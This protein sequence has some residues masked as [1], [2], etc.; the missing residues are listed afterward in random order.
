ME[1]TNT[2]KWAYVFPGQGSQW[3][4]MGY[5][6]Y[7]NYPEAKAIFD[8]SDDVMGFSLSQLC[9]QGPQEKLNQTNYA[10]PAIL[11]I[12]IAYLKT[13]SLVLPP[14]IPPAD[15]VAGHS[16]GE[17]S[18][19]VAANVLN[20][21]DAL[22]LVQLRGQLMQRE[23]EKIPSG[24][25]AVIGL[26]TSTV[27]EICRES[28]TEI[29]NNNCPGQIVISGSNEPLTKAIELAKNKKAPR[30]IPLNVAGAF[31]SRVMKG[32][33][34]ELASFIATLPFQ[35]A[36]IPIIANTSAQPLIKAGEI[37]EELV[38]QLCSCVQW[39]SS[40]EYMIKCGVTNFIEIGPGNILSG[41]IKRISREVQ[42]MSVGCVPH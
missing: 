32:A 13:L 4:G 20:L 28:E 15:F 40:T 19:L 21:R 7:Q 34:D 3:A 11:T 18:A 38:K 30:V 10:Q 2:E 27:E 26:D 25:A 39:Q 17:Y 24:M 8:E 36:S 31:H 37:K 6:L 12:S 16:L 22:H 33:S 23:S 5:D 29:A 41:L 14:N 42:I 1:N 35:D 9:F